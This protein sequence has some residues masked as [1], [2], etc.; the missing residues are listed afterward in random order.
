MHPETNNL[1]ILV[2][3]KTIAFVPNS[4]KIVIQVAGRSSSPAIDL[5][6]EEEKILSLTEEERESINAGLKPL[7]ESVVIEGV[8][9]RRRI[10]SH[11]KTMFVLSKFYIKCGVCKND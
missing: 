11:K 3:R 10:T 5:T 6:E 2:L 8:T 7:G 4:E 9:K 1:Q